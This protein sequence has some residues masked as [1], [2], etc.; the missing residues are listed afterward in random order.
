MGRSIYWLF[1]LS[2]SILLGKSS[3]YEENGNLN[4]FL[5]RRL[6]EAKTELDRIVMDANGFLVRR[7]KRDP[8][9]SAITFDKLTENNTEID[10]EIYNFDNILVLNS[11]SIKRIDKRHLQHLYVLCGDCLG[12]DFRRVTFVQMGKKHSHTMFIVIGMN[13]GSLNLFSTHSSDHHLHKYVLLQTIPSIRGSTIYPVDGKFFIE[14]GHLFLYVIYTSTNG[15]P[16]ESILFKLRNVY[17]DKEYNNI[18]TQAAKS[19]ATF[20]SGT[21]QIIIIAESAER[22]VSSQ[23]LRFSHSKRKLEII[24]LLETKRPGSVTH[25]QAFESNF[26][27][28]CEEFSPS[29]IYWWNGGEFLKWLEI[30]FMSGSC[31]FSIKQVHDQTLF[32]N[33]LQNEATIYSLGWKYIREIVTVPHPVNDD[34]KIINLFI[35]TGNI[36]RLNIVGILPKSIRFSMWDLTIISP[37]FTGGEERSA[38]EDSLTKCLG[39]A[40][41]NLGAIAKR[42]NETNELANHRLIQLDK[43]LRFDTIKVIGQNCSV[44]MNGGSAN[45]LDR[46]YADGM[47]TTDKDIDELLMKSSEFIRSSIIDQ[48]QVKFTSNLTIKNANLKLASAARVNGRNLNSGDFI[49]LEG[50]QELENLNASDIKTD[51][52]QTEDLG[53]EKIDHFI[54]KNT[55][56]N[57]DNLFLGN[58]NCKEIYSK[59]K[60]INGIDLEQ[61]VLKNRTETIHGEKRFKT[62]EVD[63][64]HGNGTEIKINNPQQKK[65]VED[66]SNVIGSNSLKLEANTIIDNLF[67]KHINGMDVNELLNNVAQSNVA[68]SIDSALTF[69]NDVK[70]DLLRGYRVLS[71]NSNSQ[72]TNSSSGSSSILSKRQFSSENEGLENAEDCVIGQEQDDDFEETGQKSRS[73]SQSE[74]P[75]YNIGK[76]IHVKGNIKANELICKNCRIVVQNQSFPISNLEEIYWTHDTRQNITVPT[77][78]NSSITA[79]EPIRANFINKQKLDC[80]LDD[81]N[82]RVFKPKFV[83]KN[84]TTMGDILDS[85][86]MSHDGLK[87]KQLSDSIVRSSDTQ[88]IKDKKNFNGGVSVN[89]LKADNLEQRSPSEL[90]SRSLRKSTDVAGPEDDRPLKFVV[91]GDLIVR[92]DLDVIYYNGIDIESKIKSAVY[93]DE[94]FDL[95]RVEFKNLETDN[96]YIASLNGE[97]PETAIKSPKPHSTIHSAELHISDNTEPLHLLDVKYMNDIKIHEHLPKVVNKTEKTL[98]RDRKIFQSHPI[99]TNNLNTEKINDARITDIYRDTLSRSKEQTIKQ[100]VTIF[101]HSYIKSLDSQKVNG[102]DANDLIDVSRNESINLDCDLVFKKLTISGDATIADSCRISQENVYKKLNGQRHLQNMHIT[103]NVSWEES[104]NSRGI[105]TMLSKA[106]TAGKKQTVTGSLIFNKDLIIKQVQHTNGRSIMKINLTHIMKD[107]LMKN[108]MNQVV[109]GEKLFLNHVSCNFMTLTGD[110]LADHI[111]QEDILNFNRTLVRKH[112]TDIVEGHKYFENG[113]NAFTLKTGGGVNGM[114]LDDIVLTNSKRVFPETIFENLEIV[115]NLDTKTYNSIDLDEF[116]K[117]RFLISEGTHQVFNG[118]ISF[119][120][121]VILKGESLVGTLNNVSIDSIVLTRGNSPLPIKQIDDCKTFNGPLKVDGIINTE[122]FNYQNLH[123][124]N[125]CSVLF[126][127]PSTIKGNIVFEN[128]VELDNDRWAQSYCIEGMNINLTKDIHTFRTTTGYKLIDEV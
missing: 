78:I 110:L 77:T 111:N 91:H 22:K 73:I 40:E 37:N 5:E 47:S 10:G 13:D 43:N 36:T 39:K 20:S 116:L 123:Q 80:I 26:V 98:I 120:D 58:L 27:F 17:L 9:R 93:R 113:F 75:R 24:Q 29:T 55:L 52:I 109:M 81:S 61:L 11:E 70:V 128:D 30:P 54:L 72:S 89:Y 104:E 18:L 21:S 101:H 63:Q 4:R 114:P 76:D 119:K 124:L 82:D 15:D 103:G 126:D 117:E 65:A 99:I 59:N 62:V 87:A 19:V 23:V 32:I 1:L 84:V 8:Q 85:S 35:S 69:L 14:S 33:I 127:G 66:S 118:S 74:Y 44:R 48:V 95:N 97:S 102:I 90:S 3:C 115:R 92:E 28:V 121:S 42:I 51:Q 56:N 67:V 68:N 122:K 6:R 88:Y 49:W 105:S 46:S 34:Q 25:F 94:D 31:L 41:G 108:K 50:E 12:I 53:G 38:V 96:I 107:S 86:D 7:T 106:V 60:R 2:A 16:S 79:N 112:S 45:I 83:F 64:L 125:E 71:A 100:P 57:W